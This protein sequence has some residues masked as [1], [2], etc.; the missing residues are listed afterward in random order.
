MI[1]LLYETIMQHDFCPVWMQC[2]GVQAVDYTQI[3][4]RV[5]NSFFSQFIIMY[6]VVSMFCLFYIFYNIDFKTNTVNMFSF[7]Q[8]TKQMEEYF[9]LCSCQFILMTA[10]KPQPMW[11][12]SFSLTSNRKGR[13][14]WLNHDIYCMPPN[15]YSVYLCRLA[16]LPL[17]SPHFP[18]SL[19]HSSLQ[20]VHVQ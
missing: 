16:W 17:N 1:L 12:W 7:R 11:I 13:D 2:T 4:P 19:L 14:G 6:T 9:I 20:L 3:L 10:L 8:K 15:A 5:S 18:C